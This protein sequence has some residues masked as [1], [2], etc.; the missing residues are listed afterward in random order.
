MR[1]AKHVARMEQ[2]GNTDRLRWRKPEGKGQL[3]QWNRVGGCGMV[4][5]GLG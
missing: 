1:G 5:C 3:E 4:C 2:K